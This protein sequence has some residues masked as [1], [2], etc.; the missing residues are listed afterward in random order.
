MF[1]YSYNQ[2]RSTCVILGTFFQIHHTSDLWDKASRVFVCWLLCHVERKWTRFVAEELQSFSMELLIWNNVLQKVDVQW[3]YSR[4]PAIH[5]M[6]IKKTYLMTN[7]KWK[8]SGEMLFS[9]TIIY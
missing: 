8:V 1:N 9:V 6:Y 2:I 5:F 4:D 3:N 7:S